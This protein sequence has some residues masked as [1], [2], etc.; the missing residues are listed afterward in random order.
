LLCWKWICWSKSKQIC[1]SNQSKLKQIFLF[2]HS[3]FWK[4]IFEANWSKYLFFYIRFILKQIYWSELKWIEVNILY[5][6]SQIEANIHQIRFRFASVHFI[7][8]NWKKRIWD[9]LHVHVEA[10]RTGL[11]RLQIEKEPLT[12]RIIA[13]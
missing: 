8:N 4:W 6:Y 12:G 9:T 7:A 11:H 13:T 1:W 5:E 3:L 2:L 10:G